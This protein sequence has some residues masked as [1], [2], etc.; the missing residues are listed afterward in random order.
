MSARCE[1]CSGGAIRPPRSGVAIQPADDD[2]EAQRLRNELLNLE[3]EA[4]LPA[5]VIADVGLLLFMKKKMCID[6]VV[7]AYVADSQE[8]VRC[9]NALLQRRSTF[10]WSH[11]IVSRASDGS[12][13]FTDEERKNVMKEWKDEYHAEPEQLAPQHHDSLKKGHGRGSWKKGHGK[14][15]HGAGVKKGG[16]PTSSGQC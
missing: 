16:W 1:A 13:V 15:A 6:G 3:E 5:A 14:L 10:M 4:P 2:Q 11:G 9:I 12:Y 8:T 7:H